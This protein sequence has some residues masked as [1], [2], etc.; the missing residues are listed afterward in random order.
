METAKRAMLKEQSVDAVTENI[1]RTNKLIRS[2][3]LKTEALSKLRGNSKTITVKHV[4]VAEGGQ[5]IIGD[6]H[7]GNTD[8]KK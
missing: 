8:G 6:V 1:N 5:A 4:T 7:Q 2:F 3:T